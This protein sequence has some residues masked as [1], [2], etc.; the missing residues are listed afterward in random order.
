MRK[1]E[2]EIAQKL[3]SVV[4]ISPIL[5]CAFNHSE[6][7]RLAA[8]DPWLGIQGLRVAGKKWAGDL[9]IEDPRVSPLHGSIMDL[10]PVLLFAGTADLLCADA[11]RLNARF[12]GKS[13]NDVVERSAEVQGLT[14]VEHQDMIHV[15]PILPHW[16]SGQARKQIV[17][18]VTEHLG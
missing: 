4:L 17:A 14:Y 1:N 13:V 6:N 2:P 3:R 18:F 11:R 16:E 5:D 15:Y 10:P 8:N 7:L 12:Q 9:P